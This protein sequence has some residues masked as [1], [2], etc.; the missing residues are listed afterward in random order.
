MTNMAIPKQTT[1]ELQRLA[2]R[3][4]K[5]ITAAEEAAAELREAVI[6]AR[7]KGATLQ[8]IADAV[9][10]SFQRAYQLSQQ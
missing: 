6:D 8:E 10:I 2:Q 1:R 9:G 5:A 3:R 7:E 4:N